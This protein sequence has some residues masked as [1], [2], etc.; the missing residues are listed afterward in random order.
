MSEKRTTQRE[1]FEAWYESQPD[2]RLQ[3]WDVWQ[4]ALDTV[5][6]PLTVEQLHEIGRTVFEKHAGRE[7]PWEGLQPWVVAFAR[8]VIA[9]TTGATQ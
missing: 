6:V 7:Y 2:G 5:R 8:A 9:K 1:K 3:P 4:A